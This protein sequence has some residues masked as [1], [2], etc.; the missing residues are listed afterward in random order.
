[1]A[2]VRWPSRGY[3]EFNCDC[4][5]GPEATVRNRAAISDF[6]E[7]SWPDRPSADPWPRVYGVSID[8]G[9]SQEDVL[10]FHRRRNRSAG[11]DIT[12]RRSLDLYGNLYRRSRES[13]RSSC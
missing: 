5:V 3:R 8:L 2:W 7:F 11:I 6:L 4:T 1:M 13:W 9:P 12:F 10:Q